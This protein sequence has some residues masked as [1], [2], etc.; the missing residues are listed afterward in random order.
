VLFF[1]VNINDTFNPVKVPNGQA[2]VT[3]LL[4]SFMTIDP[5]VLAAIAAVCQDDTNKWFNF[6]NA[7]TFLAPTCPVAAKAAKKGMVSF[8]ANISST[9][10]KAQGGL[11]GDCK[12]PGKGLTGMALCYHKYAEFKEL[13]KDQQ[14]ELSKWHKANGCNKE[15]KSGKGGKGRG[16]R[17]PSRSPWNTNHTTKKFKSMI[18]KMEA[19]QT[20]MYEAMADVQATSIAAIHATSPGTMP[21]QGHWLLV[22]WL[23]FHL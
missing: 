13:P 21:P 16:K 23:E 3:Y 7:F 4:S 20:K 12:K 18:S 10:T 22:R 5:S 15:E 19:C 8:D 6:E 11:G 17:S 14:D 1:Y 2:C 9:S